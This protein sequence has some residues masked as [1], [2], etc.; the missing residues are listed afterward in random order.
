[1]GAWT[2]LMSVVLCVH[3]AAAAAE[4]PP[5]IDMSV[6]ATVAHASPGQTFEVV[7]TLAIPTGWYI[8][9]KDPGS[10][11]MPTRIG[12]T[13]PEGCVVGPTRF[14]RPQLVAGTTG[15]V[16]VHGG[17]SRFAVQLTLPDSW[18]AGTPVPLGIRADWLA[19]RTQ[20]WLGESSATLDVPTAAPAGGPTAAAT[21]ARAIPQPVSTRPRT[22]TQLKGPTLRISGPTDPAGE[23]DFLPIRAAGVTYGV[24]VMTIDQNAFVLTVPLDYDEA[25][26]GDEAM[27]LEGLL[28]FG[29]GVHDP[30]WMVN[31]PME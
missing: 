24:P 14:P 2:N 10:S 4:K 16:R 31:L 19:C 21:Q 25:K 27:R 5:Q 18:Q 7:C 30:A 17:T 13:A 12:V 20:C 26:A 28:T 29:D 15:P 9:W 6:A 8:Y 22:I 3:G 23:P 1:M 11:G